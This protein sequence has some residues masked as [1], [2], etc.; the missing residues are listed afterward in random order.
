MDNKH[1]QEHDFLAGGGEMAE[2]IRTKNWAETPLG[3]IESWPIS[4]KIVIRIYA[5][6]TT[7]HLGRGRKT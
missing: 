3:S 7:T 2:L 1:H 6:L 4:L 5:Y